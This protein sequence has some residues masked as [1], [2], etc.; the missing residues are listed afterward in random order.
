MKLMFAV[1]NYHKEALNFSEVEDEVKK[2]FKYR[3]VDDGETPAFSVPGVLVIVSTNIGREVKSWLDD[4]CD[5]DDVD[6]SPQWTKKKNWKV[7]GPPNS[8][9]SSDPQEADP[10]SASGSR[11]SKR[12]ATPRQYDVKVER[13]R[14]G[15][16][17]EGCC[18]VV[19]NAEATS[20]LLT[21][22]VVRLLR[23]MNA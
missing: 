22:R 2:A 9:A 7:L 18:L 11:T 10:A 5:V 3:D 13:I 12:G 17:P 19:L 21:E 1:K 14:R 4:D 16:I 6:S 15:S 20:E 8:D 23:D